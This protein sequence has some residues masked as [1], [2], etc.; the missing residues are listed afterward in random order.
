MARDVGRLTD[1]V[2]AHT[3]EEVGLRAGVIVHDEAAR[4]AEHPAEREGP[5]DRIADDAPV[6]AVA[7]EV[8]EEPRDRAEKASERREAIPD[9]EQED[10]VL[11]DDLGVIGD[12]VEHVADDEAPR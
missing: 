6:H 1:L 5:R 4:A 7:L 8:D 11:E 9:A 12:R 10:R 2:V 3:E